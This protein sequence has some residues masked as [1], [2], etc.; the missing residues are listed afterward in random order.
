M[1][2]DLNKLQ[3]SDDS[4]TNCE[5]FPNV[6]FMKLGDQRKLLRTCGWHRQYQTEAFQWRR[7]ILC[8]TELFPNLKSAPLSG[9]HPQ[10]LIM[11]RCYYRCN[12]YPFRLNFLR[13]NYV[14]ELC[15]FVLRLSRTS[16]CNVSGLII[17][18][19]GFPWAH[20]CKTKPLHYAVPPELRPSSVC[21]GSHSLRHAWL[22]CV[23]TVCITVAG[24]DIAD[25]HY[26]LCI[27]SAFLQTLLLTLI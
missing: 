24:I 20:F 5:M 25:A 7:M 14:C 17:L 16:I 15:M 19:R 11:W 2:H 6:S 23:C 8:Q 18:T 3:C 10:S 13:Y 22:W 1:F 12:S 26:A 9:T 27:W 21:L 4:Y